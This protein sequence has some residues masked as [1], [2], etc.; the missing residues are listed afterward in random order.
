MIKIKICGMVNPLNLKE[1]AAAGPDFIGLIYFP[2]SPRYVGTETEHDL[3]ENFPQGIKRVGVFFNENIMKVLKVSKR[4]TLD[5]IQ[6]HGNES[7]AYCN[8]L[9]MSG[10]SVIKAFNIEN[11]FN[12]ETLTGYLPACD[13]FLFDTKSG[14]PG[15]SGIKFN[16]HK[17]DEYKLDKPFI[18]SGGIGPEDAEL[19][20]SIRNRALYAV[21]INSRF[22]SVAGIKDVELVRKFI[23]GIKIDMQ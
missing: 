10:W 21:D 11:E 12:F 2:G 14:K 9:R 15:G 5:L 18:L 22:E 20:K 19:V 1:V 4:A 3:L 17:L 23:E 7:P 16:W 6:L 13:F 8:W